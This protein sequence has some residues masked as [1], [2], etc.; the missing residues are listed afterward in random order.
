MGDTFDFARVSAVYRHEK[1]KRT[2]AA[3]EPEFYALLANHLERLHA[4][5]ARAR[6]DTKPTRARLLEDEI[7]KT[8]RM[9]EQIFTERERKIALLA[10]ARAAGSEREVRGLADEEMALLDRLVAELQT[11]RAQ[12]FGRA[13]PPPPP[14]ERRPAPEAAPA[15][16]PPPPK[17]ALADVTVVEMVADV[18]PFAGI[19]VTYRLQKGDVLTL[20]KTI[21]ALLVDRGK[22]RAVNLPAPAAPA[23]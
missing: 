16:P 6:E 19:N 3:L 5:V 21:A 18:P 13:P 2:L 8:E 9:R 15:V 4:E 22:A 17:P 12:A 23:T 1:D 11:A 20:P 7:A 10:S 14:V